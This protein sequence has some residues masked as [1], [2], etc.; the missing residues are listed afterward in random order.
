[1]REEFEVSQPRPP[2][3]TWRQRAWGL[4]QHHP[5]CSCLTFATAVLRSYHHFLRPSLNFWPDLPFT[6]LTSK[7]CWIPLT[8][9]LFHG[10]VGATVV[11]V[12]LP[13][14]PGA[15]RG[16]S[17]LRPPALSGQR[18]GQRRRSRGWCSVAKSEQQELRCKSWEACVCSTSGLAGEK[19]T[20]IGTREGHNST[21]GAGT[22]KVLYHLHAQKSSQF[23]S[24]S[25][26]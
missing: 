9:L 25:S 8:T 21:A 23:C 24:P 14:N 13:A 20:W 11:A 17:L 7:S 6:I 12:F 26:P 22:S 18:G 16:H 2:P 4:R 15:G 19:K 3:P 1:M 5:T 10:Q